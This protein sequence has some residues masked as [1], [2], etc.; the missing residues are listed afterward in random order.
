MKYGITLTRLEE[1]KLSYL[2][3]NSPKFRIRQRAHAILLYSKNY[4]IDNLAGIFDVHRDTINRWLVM[5]DQKGVLGL[6]D[7]QRSGRPHINRK[8][9]DICCDE[10]YEFDMEV[11]N[12]TMQIAD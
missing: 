5:W 7:I 4:D 1:R 12:S 3:R 2:I 10:N 6:Y 9:D 11:L 8:H